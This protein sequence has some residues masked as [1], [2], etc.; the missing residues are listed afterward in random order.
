MPSLSAQSIR[1]EPA[2]STIKAPAPLR[3]RVT[4][5]KAPIRNQEPTDTF[6]E[7]G[8][9]VQSI[10]TARDVPAASASNARSEPASLQ[11]AKPATVQSRPI[12]VNIPVTPSAARGGPKLQPKIKSRTTAS[13]KERL[14]AVIQSVSAKPASKFKPLQIV[15]PPVEKAKQADPPVLVTVALAEKPLEI[16][17]GATKSEIE[18]VIKASFLERLYRANKAAAGRPVLA[19]DMAF[20]GLAA[21][22]LDGTQSA[23]NLNVA[24]RFVVARLHTRFQLGEWQDPVG[25]PPVQHAQKLCDGI[26]VVETNEFM[27][28]KLKPELEASTTST[29]TKIKAKGRGKVK[30]PVVAK[31]THPDVP[32]IVRYLIVGE[33]GD[34]ISRFEQ[35]L[36]L[37][38]PFDITLSNFGLRPDWQAYLE[39]KTDI[40]RCPSTSAVLLD[41]V[42]TKH[43]EDFSQG[44]ARIWLKRM[45]ANLDADVV[46]MAKRYVLSNVVLNR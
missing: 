16:P 11:A 25:Y 1:T 5:S 31:V 37:F 27:V 13:Q 4:S 45:E 32:S 40:S 26:W 6:N 9:A 3:N 38:T 42:R 34:V 33:T 17:A 7:T 22:M 41:R 15:R 12:E 39:S 20:D 46:R 21:N 43:E 23:E 19:D 30:V 24:I 36:D 14:R 8:P 2:R 28:N 10:R 18:K 29:K 35:P 44:I